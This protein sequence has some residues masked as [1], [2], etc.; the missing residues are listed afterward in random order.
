[1]EVALS[2]RLVKVVESISV[3]SILL[4]TNVLLLVTP[5]IIRIP[6]F[7]NKLLAAAVS[8]NRA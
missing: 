1:M 2:V 8:E 7:M 5:F 4:L 6:Q 3:L